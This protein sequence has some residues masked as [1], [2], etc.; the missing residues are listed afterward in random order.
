M[1]C[2]ITQD[3]PEAETQQVMG[4]NSWLLG[5]GG[6]DGGRKTMLSPSLG[7]HR[8][9]WCSECCV[10]RAGPVIYGE[11]E[12]G[13]SKGPGSCAFS[14]AKKSGAKEKKRSE[15]ALKLRGGP[16]LGWK[17]RLLSHTR[18][19]RRVFKV[20]PKQKGQTKGQN[21]IQTGKTEKGNTCSTQWTNEAFGRITIQR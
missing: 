1:I 17:V 8:T 11:A 9:H 3:G 13:H 12:C 15:R 20:F 19:N 7:F 18:A 4:V 6:A 5:R 10:N 2:F 14:W 21:Q 16:T